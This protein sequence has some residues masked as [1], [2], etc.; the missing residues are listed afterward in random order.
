MKHIQCGKK[1]YTLKENSEKKLKLK[2]IKDNQEHMN[3]NIIF[4]LRT[5]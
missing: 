3:I 5:C 4:I 2:P 1:H